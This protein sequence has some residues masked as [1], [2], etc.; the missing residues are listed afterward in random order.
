M[1]KKPDRIPLP[2]ILEMKKEIETRPKY[3]R[4]PVWKKKQKQLL[5]DT[6]LRDYDI[7]KFYWREVKQDDGI[8]Y[9][10]ID[11]QQR[12]L[13]IWEFH[14]DGY[15]L[16]RDAKPI[17][18]FEVKGLKYSKLPHQIKRIFSRYVIDVVI[19]IEAHEDKHEAEIRDMFIRLQG[20]TPLKPQEKRN[21]MTGDMRDFVTEIAEHPFFESCKFSNERFAFDHMAAQTILLELNH[22]ATNIRDKA[23][24][25][26][27]ETHS[28]FNKNGKIARK[29]KNTY[30]FL[31]TAFPKKSPY[32]ERYN[33]VNLYCIASFLIEHYVFKDFAEPLAKWFVKFEIE[34]HANDK[35]DE[36]EQLISLL[37]YRSLI[38][39]SGDTKE[40]I[41]AR[42]KMLKERFFLEYPDIK[43][44]DPIRGFN[45]K[46]RLEIYG[47]DEGRCQLKIKCNGE[48]KLDWNNGWHADHKIS[49]TN[50]G[51]TT[52]SNGQVACPECNLSKG[53]NG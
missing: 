46:E 49:H 51:K 39:S 7:P 29:V 52:V 11:G 30:D 37:K 14:D 27:Y 8:E 40:Y 42:L 44:I 12:L 23:L 2:N 45:D 28:E 15:A 17:N 53:G 25:E 4:P 20:G 41:E 32:L 9:E 6:I 1:K 38:K 26:M 18:G 34:R 36:E 21:A 5:M 10:V 19:I 35:K 31:H 33:V 43:K 50:G 16:E 22:G 24:N 48:E 13:A 47:R 3:Q